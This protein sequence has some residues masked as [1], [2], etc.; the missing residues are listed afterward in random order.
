[1]HHTRASSFLAEVDSKTC[2]D[3]FLLLCLFNDYLLCLCYRRQV[4]QMSVFS[5]IL[6]ANAKNHIR[7]M[8]NQFLSLYTIV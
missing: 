8:R 3:V 6:L 2:C 4:G 1:M 7:F 5:F